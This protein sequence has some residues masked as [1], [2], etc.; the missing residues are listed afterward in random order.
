MNKLFESNAR[1][2]AIPVTLDTQ[3]IYHDTPYI[4]YQQ[5]SL[6]ENF[7][8]YSTQRCVLK[9]SSEQGYNFHP[10]KKASK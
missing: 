4:S 9:K 7:Q 6:N 10:I 5:I 8:A 1:V 2:D 3:I